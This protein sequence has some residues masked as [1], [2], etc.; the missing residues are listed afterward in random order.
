MDYV[1]EYITRATITKI[2]A[3]S[4][5][6]SLSM[7]LEPDRAGDMPMLNNLSGM[8]CGIAF[9][10]DQAVIDLKTGEVR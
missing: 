3:D 8:P 10:P 7:E 6:I 2:T 5:K 9:E 4:K 1:P